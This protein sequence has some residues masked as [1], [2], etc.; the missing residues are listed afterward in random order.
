MIYK[1]IERFEEFYKNPIVKDRYISL[2]TEHREDV[3]KE[4]RRLV[5]KRDM[6]DINYAPVLDEEEALMSVSMPDLQEKKFL[7]ERADFEH[8]V[9]FGARESPGFRKR[10]I[11]YDS[12]DIN[13]QDALYRFIKEFSDDVGNSAPPTEEILKELTNAS[14]LDFS[15]VKCFIEFFLVGKNCFSDPELDF[16]ENAFAL[17]CI[18]FYFCLKTS[19]ELH[20]DTL[21]LIEDY[22]R[23]G[24][25]KRWKIDL[26]DSLTPKM[27]SY[28]AKEYTNETILADFYDIIGWEF[29]L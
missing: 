8:H 12:T 9:Q 20:Y 14:D 3:A 24:Q 16:Y 28:L 26:K 5:W 23:D 2:L 7:T 11:Q 1:K 25:K 13:F 4:E 6:Y 15:A 17:I 27:E 22:L 21:T 10:R 18:E 19:R 29:D